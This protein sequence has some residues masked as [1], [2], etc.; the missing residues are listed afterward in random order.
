MIYY[1]HAIY[2]DFSTRVSSPANRIFKGTDVNIVIQNFK[3]IWQG[4][5]YNGQ[6]VIGIEIEI[7]HKPLCDG[8][9]RRIF[10]NEESERI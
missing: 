7:C 4:S 8:I 3:K 5:T 9:K 1:L 10:F 6:K 2:D